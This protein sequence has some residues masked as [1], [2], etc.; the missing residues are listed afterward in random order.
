MR[1]SYQDDSADQSGGAEA[2]QALIDDFNP[3][4]GVV[5]GILGTILY[6]TPVGPVLLAL[7]GYTGLYE[8]KRGIE[9]GDPAR[10]GWGVVGSIPMLGTISRSGRLGAGLGAARAFKGANTWAR[11]ATLPDHFKRH[12]S[13]FSARTAD[14]Y[15]EMASNFFRRSQTERLPT[16]IDSSG[17]IRI[18]DPRTNSFG[19]YNPSG[20]TKTFY[21]PDPAVHGHPTNL[22]YWNAQPGVSP[23]TP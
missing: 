23:W 1:V 17:T 21:K 2:E 20:R 9:T 18:Y 6:T 14:D 5:S 15:A 11:P 12:G 7:S 3:K 10:V 4:L 16:K 8:V 13:A 22:D 19:S